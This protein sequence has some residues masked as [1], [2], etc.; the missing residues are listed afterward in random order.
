M[1]IALPA[2]RQ[3]RLD[4]AI[5]GFTIM[6]MDYPVRPGN[7]SEVKGNDKFHSHYQIEY[8]VT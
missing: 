8:V 1:V 2:Y 3:G 4:E 6:D 7:Y 5:Q